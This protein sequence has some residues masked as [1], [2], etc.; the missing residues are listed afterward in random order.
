MAEIANIVLI[1]FSV[2]VVIL[3]ISRVVMFVMRKT[4]H[5]RQ[6]SHMAKKFNSATEYLRH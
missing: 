1:V 5:A 2:L 3:V 6:A 4:G